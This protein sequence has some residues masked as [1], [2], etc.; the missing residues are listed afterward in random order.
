MATAI[1]DKLVTIAKDTG[2]ER[3]KAESIWVQFEDF[4]GAVSECAEKVDGLEITDVSQK[5]EMKLARSTR[6]KLKNIRVAA[7]KKKKTLKDGILKEGRFIDATYRL[8]AD[9][10]KPVEADLL[11]KENYAKRKDAERKAQLLA[12]RTAILEPLGVDTKYLALDVMGED[13]WEDLVLR[14]REIH[15]RHQERLRKEEE[16]RQARE[17]AEAEERA[18]AQA[19]L[20]RM[21]KE[22]EERERKLAQEREEERRRFEAEQAALRKERELAEEAVRKE[23]EA[24]EEM[25]R[26]ERERQEEELREARA[27]K[28]R[29]E[30]ELR[31]KEAA[32]LAERQRAEAE[33]RRLEQAGDKEKLLAYLKAVKSIEV[34]TVDSDDASH[35]VFV[36]KAAFHNATEYVERLGQ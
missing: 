1:N 36:L 14:S 34:P 22:Q 8:I 2:I 24:R 13:D 25:E 16:E 11:E 27:E 12:E 3:V 4:F 9:A 29:V 31:E 7:E 15:E 5:K 20:A 17:K 19:E 6:L 35:V 21:R 26:K 28:E 10:T 30:R 33:R 23:R 32:E 18:R